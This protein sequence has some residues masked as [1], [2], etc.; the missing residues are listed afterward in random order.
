MLHR[1]STAPAR[2]IE[3]HQRP[4]HA[5]AQRIEPQRVKPCLNSL[6]GFAGRRLELHQALERPESHLAETRPLALNPLVEGR[7]VDDERVEQV[8]C[9]QRCHPLQRFSRPAAD[10]ALE[11]SDVDP[12]MRRVERDGRRGGQQ[13]RGARPGQGLAQREQRLAQ[14]GL[15]LARRGVRP[16]QPLNLSRS[17]GCP[18]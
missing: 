12:E 15:R 9:V 18:G 10:V 6:F 7:L 3:V 13:G 5:L 17:C 8:P 16:E 4:V 1:G 14:A 2:G 11:D